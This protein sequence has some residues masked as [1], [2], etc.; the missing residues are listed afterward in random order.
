MSEQESQRDYLHRQIAERLSRLESAAAWYR[1]T[2]F[3]GQMATVVLSATITIIAGMKYLSIVSTVASDIVL[4]LGALVTVISTWGAFF[5]PRES[6]HLNNAT[7]TR[8]RALQAKLEFLERGASFEQDQ[9]RVLADGFAEYQRILDD[10]N[11][12][13]Q[14]LRSKAK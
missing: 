11:E 1:K 3:R 12:H 6:W 5:S 14:N 8:L 13:W 10:Y 9:L 7:Y 2:H 4:V